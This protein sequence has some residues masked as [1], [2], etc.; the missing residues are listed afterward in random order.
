MSI[1]RLNV[2]RPRF[3]D[4]LTLALCAGILCPPGGAFA[5]PHHAARGSSRAGFRAGA[6]AGARH[7]YRQ[8]FHHGAHRGY[9]AGRHAGYHHG[10]HG[11]VHFGFWGSWWH[12]I[13][14]LVTTLAVTAIVVSAADKKEYHYDQGVY[15][16]PASGGY[17]V[18]P[19]PLGATVPQ[20]PANSVGVLVSGREYFYYGGAFYLADSG[21]YTVVKAPPGAVV[22]SLPDGTDTVVVAGNTYFK[23]ADTYYQAESQGG[24]VVYGVVAKPA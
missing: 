11:G 7:G 20:L 14:F 9:H 4:V 23:Y 15:Y 21:K 19:A 1:R 5:F 6:H 17:K 10:W 3:H 22:S 12:P 8:G 2:L 13:G 24:G 16:V 18:V